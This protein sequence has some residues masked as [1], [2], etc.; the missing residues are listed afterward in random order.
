MWSVF[1]SQFL[2]FLTST[3][4]VSDIN[5]MQDIFPKIIHSYNVRY[6]SSRMV[7]WEACRVREKLVGWQKYNLYMET[8]GMMIVYD[9]FRKMW[10]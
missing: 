6:L 8:L 9:D 10:G 7:K 3:T 5:F 1:F 2:Y 4:Q